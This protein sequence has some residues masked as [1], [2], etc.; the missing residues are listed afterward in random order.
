MEYKFT[1]K[2]RQVIFKRQ[3][4]LSRVI[5]LVLE[6]RG[7]T[8]NAELLPDFSGFIVKGENE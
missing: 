5:G 3:E 8:G 2:E 4:E 6:L 7:V 1:D